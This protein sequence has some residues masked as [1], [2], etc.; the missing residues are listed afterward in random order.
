MKRG[1]ILFVF[2]FC[3]KAVSAYYYNSFES[4]I[5]GFNPND[6]FLFS[7]F[8]LFFFFL[9][10]IF[11]KVFKDPEG[12]PSKGVW[13]PS[14]AATML[15]VHGISRMDLDVSNFLYGFGFSGAD[16]ATLS[17]ILVV[18]VF[19]ILAVKKKLKWFF[20]LIGSLL[21]LLGLSGA[22]YNGGEA[23]K[24]GI[25]LIAI[26]ILGSWAWRK[27]K[28]RSSYKERLSEWEAKQRL[29]ELKRKA[30]EKKAGEY[31]EVLGRAAGKIYGYSKAKIKKLRKKGLF[32][33][34]IG[35]RRGGKKSNRGQFVSK[36]AAE[37]YAQRF[38]DAAARKR[39]GA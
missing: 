26:G 15:I 16:F 18:M 19:L 34:K 14:L 13:I 11:G 35:M 39:F 38:G 9:N 27:V 1:L 24:W 22:V 28:R 12:T 7:M 30:F 31:G 10:W 33:Y 29:K 21:L 3:L 6:I 5:S 23:I 8:I 17:W 25:L 37:R 2:L 4:F 32:E 36:A 20:I